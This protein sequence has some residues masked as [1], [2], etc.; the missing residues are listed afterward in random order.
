MRHSSQILLPFGFR[1]VMA[2]EM[3]HLDSG[4][5]KEFANFVPWQYDDVRDPMKGA[6]KVKVKAFA[7]SRLC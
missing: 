1:K 7:L 3:T 5:G 2:I 4:A 6:R